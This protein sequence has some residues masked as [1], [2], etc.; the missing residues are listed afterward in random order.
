MTC[1]NCQS[2]LSQNYC[3]NCGKTAR[4]PKINFGYLTSEV[5]EILMLE[6]GFFFTVKELLLRPGD[7]VRRFIL[8]DRSRLLKPILFIVMTSLIYSLLNYYFPFEAKYNKSSTVENYET[9]INSWVMANYGYSNLMMGVFIAYFTKLFFRKSGY[10][11]FEI[12]ILICYT[13]GMAM[14]LLGI[15]GFLDNRTDLPFMAI[16]GIVG[17]MYIS[18]ANGQFFGKKF[19]NY[20][21]AFAAYIIGTVTFFLAVFLLGNALNVIFRA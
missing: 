17:M 16:G 2:T 15:F 14:L 11:I 9:K 6:K 18:W 1:E 12:L 13:M 4:V 10:N 19:R 8:K 7:N 21:K 20:W 5:G 3:P